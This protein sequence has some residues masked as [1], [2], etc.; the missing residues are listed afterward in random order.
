[1]M[2]RL[3]EKIIFQAVPQRLMRRDISAK[4]PS[5]QEENRHTM[6][7]DMRRRRCKIRPSIRARGAGCKTGRG[8][9]GR[10]RCRPGATY[11]RCA[12]A[13][14]GPLPKQRPA[15]HAYTRTVRL[16]QGQHARGVRSAERRGGMRRNMGDGNKAF[17]GRNTSTRWT[18]CR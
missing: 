10:C 2:H 15:G 8:G 11:L 18:E 17:A 5:H 13:Y 12:S 14:T 7:K 9:S 16:W 4:I 1:M 6:C 3:R